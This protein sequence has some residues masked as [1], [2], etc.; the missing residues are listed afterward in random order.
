[1]VDE[2]VAGDGDQPRD[3]EIR[4]LVVA[5]GPDR[6][7]ERLARQVFGDRGVVHARREIAVDLGECPVVER[8]EHRSLVGGGARVHIS[9]IARGRV[10]PTGAP[11]KSGN[12]LHEA[13]NLDQSGPEAPVDRPLGGVGG[14]NDLE[15]DDVVHLVGT[16]AQDLEPELAGIVV[17]AR[18][19]RL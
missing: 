17:D 5:H 19:R 12:R 8:E 15:V 13:G 10:L 9:I 18:H 3:R 14:G 4:N 16:I 1:M 7:E 2:L 11:E 6:G